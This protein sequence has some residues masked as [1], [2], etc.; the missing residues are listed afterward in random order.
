MFG[1]M[2]EV[3]SAIEDIRHA[4]GDDQIAAAFKF[5]IDTARHEFTSL[6]SELENKGDEIKE[7]ESQI[8]EN[9]NQHA[10]AIHNFLDCVDRPVGRL[11]Y[12]VDAKPSTDQAILGLFDAINRNP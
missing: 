12:T 1:G 5:A 7:L 4:E 8:E 3:I 11:S 9:E 2:E 6:E 10:D